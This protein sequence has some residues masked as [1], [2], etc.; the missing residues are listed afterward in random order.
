MARYK[1]I[2]LHDGTE[3]I[4]KKRVSIEV[5]RYIKGVGRIIVTL[6]SGWPMEGKVIKVSDKNAAKELVREFFR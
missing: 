6:K 4:I 5:R 1:A 3:N 2:E